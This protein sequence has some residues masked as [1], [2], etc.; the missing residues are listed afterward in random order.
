MKANA[1]GSASM[2]NTSGTGP[3]STH[4]ATPTPGAPAP[5]GTTPAPAASGSPG[6]A[7]TSAAQQTAKAKKIEELKK[8]REKQR[9]DT[10]DKIRT[11]KLKEGIQEAEARGKLDEL[12]PADRTWVDADPR[13]KD[14]AYD[15]DQKKFKVEEGRASL[16][17]EKDGIL[18]GPVIRSIDE[19]GGGGGGDYFDGKGKLWDLK[20]ARDGAQ[21][22]A[23][24]ANPKG[25]Q[26]GENILVDCSNF[27]VSQQKA[28]ERAIKRRL[29]AGSSEVRF[30]PKR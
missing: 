20:D 21:A 25:G 19:H 23:D 30:V 10:E 27:T 5:A 12:N 24:A 28:L 22:I 16:Q 8:Q 4:D 2:S 26:P 6:A 3:A 11:E 9:K 14:L 18:D 17:A 13:H 7:N 29:K 15:P 1:S